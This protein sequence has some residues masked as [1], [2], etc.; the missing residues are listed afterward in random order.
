[1]TGVPRYVCRTHGVELA[2]EDGRR[3]IRA[4]FMVTCLLMT[5]KDVREG[6]FGE[7]EIARVG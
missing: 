2:A 6:K 3:I 5:M 7:C 1:V 4:P